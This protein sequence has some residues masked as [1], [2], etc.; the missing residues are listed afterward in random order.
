MEE[1]SWSG[2]I[3]NLI[4][5]SPSDMPKTFTFLNTFPVPKFTDKVKC[6]QFLKAY[7]QCT[8]PVIV[9]TF[10]KQ[11]AS[12]IISNLESINGKSRRVKSFSMLGACRLEICSYGTDQTDDVFIHIPL[13][14][15]ASH[16]YGSRSAIEL[17]FFY[18]TIQFA[19]FVAFCA[20]EV[21]KESSLIGPQK[22]SREALCREILIRVERNL[23]T[24][25]GSMFR[26]N[27]EQ[28]GKASERGRIR[29]V[30]LPLNVSDNLEKSYGNWLRC[31]DLPTGTCDLVDRKYNVIPRKPSATYPPSLFIELSVIFEKNTN[32]IGILDEKN[33]ER[34]SNFGRAMGEAYSEERQKDLD[35][36][37]NENRR[38]LH[39]EIPHSN[40]SRELWMEQFRSLQPGQLYFLRALG[41]LES[42]DYLLALIGGPPLPSW[43]P[44]DNEMKGDKCEAVIKC[45][46]WIQKKLTK[47]AISLLPS[48][49]VT[50]REMQ[51]Y[52]IGI[53]DDG[54]FVIRWKHPNGENRDLYLSAKF[55][56]PKSSRDSRA[57]SFTEFGIDIVD[58]SG[59]PLRSSSV[60]DLSM[61]KASIPKSSF[62][63][64]PPGQLLL[65]LWENVCQGRGDD[66]A[67]E[68]FVKE[69]R[70][71]GSKGQKMLM[72]SAT[73]TQISQQNIPPLEN[74]ANYLLKEFLDERFPNGGIFR[75]AP[76]EKIPDSTEDLKAFIAFCRRPDYIKHPYS[77]HWLGMM[78][79]DT[80]LVADIGKNIHV[81]RNCTSERYNGW[82]NHLKKM[83]GE[84][85]FHIGPIRGQEKA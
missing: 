58:G 35:R 54:I 38:E 40:E 9:T 37:W 84:V 63:G 47:N 26:L 4:D 41:H 85:R 43:H 50:A 31:Q 30:R 51:G 8:R 48:L 75:T 5:H 79:R 28:A 6:L 16:Q 52:P 22:S 61:S 11:A 18:L 32:S 24:E 74:D 82:Q 53:K 81:L 44:T 62:L 2:M 60:W 20:K 83:V 23:Q 71:W 3:G 72:R 70:E 76:R 12:A 25:T 55:A 64:R 27:I 45:G 68:Q 19:F 67:E 29:A 78:E 15:P 14:H 46:F 49:Y 73:E 33:F 69:S 13:K 1:R 66:G 39:R 77:P 42:H 80:P 57:L 21:I 34:I 56:A 10:G 65:D 36:V 7:F 17:R 59:R